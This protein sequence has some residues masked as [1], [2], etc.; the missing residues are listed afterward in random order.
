MS[1]LCNTSIRFAYR[2]GRIVCHENDRDSLNRIQLL[3]QIHDLFARPRIEI[4]GRFVGHKNGGLVDQG[5]GDC[6]VLLLAAG[7][8]DPDGGLSGL[9]DRRW[10]IPREHGHGVAWPACFARHKAAATRR[11][12]RCGAGQQIEILKHE[13]DLI[14][15]EF[16][17][18]IGRHGYDLQAVQQVASTLWVIEATDRIH[19]ARLPQPGRP[20]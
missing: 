6:H 18:D 8:A 3:E 2:D 17:T 5:P 7:K 16:G 12:P 9:Q 14:A 15:A 13:P 1:P 19:E 4:S 11:S 10:S 20:S